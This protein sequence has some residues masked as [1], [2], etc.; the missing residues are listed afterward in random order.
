MCICKYWFIF[1]KYTNIRVTK[2]LSYNDL[3][4]NRNLVQNNFQGVWGKYF[5]QLMPFYNKKKVFS[6]I[7]QLSSYICEQFWN[8][9]T[10]ITIAQRDKK[11]NY[12]FQPPFLSSATNIYSILVQVVKVHLLYFVYSQIFV[13]Y[14]HITIRIYL[15]RIVF[16]NIWIDDKLFTNIPKKQNYNIAQQESFKQLWK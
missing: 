4:S 8:N 16:L 3:V 13:L 2:S 11:S 12:Y 5:R 10:I 14:K 7:M 1:Y 15:L 6:A 9:Q